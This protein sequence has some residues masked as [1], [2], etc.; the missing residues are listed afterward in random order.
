MRVPILSAVL[1]LSCSTAAA[2]DIYR[3]VDENGKA[4]VSDVVPEK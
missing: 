4:H 2:V 3:W 1:M